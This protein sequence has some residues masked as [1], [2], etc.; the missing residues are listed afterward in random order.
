MSSMFINVT[1]T[2]LLAAS[3]SV[4][5]GGTSAKRADESRTIFQE[6]E[7]EA[8]AL[9]READQFVAITSNPNLSAESHLTEL[10]A[11]KQDINSMG[12]EIRSLEA[13]R[14]TLPSW[15]QQAIAK[16]LPLLKDSAANLDSAINF[17]D[18]NRPHLWMGSAYRNYARNV[19]QDSERLEKTLNHALK[20]DKIHRQEQRLNET[21][22][23]L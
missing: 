6:L 7:S 2:V 3:P 9:H 5:K 8:A 13:E 17:Y 18:D 16:A 4:L 12:R 11:M 19:N 10:E 22:A 15:E 20:L 21:V 23:S 1:L 14:E